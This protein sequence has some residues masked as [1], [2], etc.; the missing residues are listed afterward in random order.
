MKLNI[1]AAAALGCALA[2]AALTALPQAHA[3]SA[4][5]MYYVTEI[6]VSDEAAYA[7]T[8]GP[9]IRAS[10]AAAGGKVLAASD[11]PVGVEGDAPKTRVVISVWDSMDK[12]SAW[13]AS[14][15]FKEARI[16][17]DKI[18]KFRSYAIPA[19]AP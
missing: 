1:P 4:Q 3:Q 9:K 18:A 12:L 16:E 7:K 15:A 6:D 8:Y 11:K 14:A 19:V 2:I 5:Q 13:R 10:L 17:G